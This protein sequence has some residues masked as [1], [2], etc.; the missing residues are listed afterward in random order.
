M[1]CLP[2]PSTQSKEQL[3][4]LKAKKVCVWCLIDTRTRVPQTTPHGTYSL[5]TPFTPQAAAASAPP[6]QQAAAA[7]ASRPAAAQL[8][9]GSKAAA[10]LPLDFFDTGKVSVPGVLIGMLGT[11][12]HNEVHALPC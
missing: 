8:Q 5:N 2:L 7:A 6:P 3:K 12:P 4:A 9:P 10:A 1:L 11:Q